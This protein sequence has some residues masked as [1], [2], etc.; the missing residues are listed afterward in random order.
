MKFVENAAGRKVPVEIN[1][2]KAT[3]FMGVNVPKDVSRKAAPPVRQKMNYGIPGEKVFNNLKDALEFC[4]IDNGQTVSTHHHLRNGDKVGGLLFD[5]IH[6]IGV[7]DVVWFP[8]ATFPCHDELLKYFEDGTIHHLEA[9][10]KGE[11]GKWVTGGHMTERGLLVVRSHGGRYLAIQNGDMKVDIAVVA[12]STADGFGNANGLYGPA[13][14]GHMG[15]AKADVE[16][17]EHVIVVTDNLVDFPMEGPWQIEGWQVDAVVKVDSIGDPEK[18]VSGT[19]RLPEEEQ[20]LYIA[21]LAAKFCDEAG[22]IKQGFS[23]QGGASGMVLAAAHYISEIMDKKGVKGSFARGGSTKYLV[24]M[25]EKGQ[26]GR[27]LDGQL[28][29]AAAVESMRKNHRT[30][31]CTNPAVSYSPHGKGRLAEGVDIA[32]LGAMEIDLEY[33]VN[34][35]TFSNGRIA[36][37]I[38]GFQNCLGG[39]CVMILAPAR[40]KENIIVR[41][42]VTT[43]VAPGETV[44]VWVSDR[45]IAIN[46]KRQDLLETIKGS[47]LP[48]RK[49]EEIQAEIKKE[50]PNSPTDIP[51][52]GDKAVGV[53]MWEDETVIDTLWEVPAFE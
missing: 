53:V 9:S 23:F 4:N 17:A 28:F 51:K 21:D 18:I 42:R 49:I 24:D 15:F 6:E 12:A 25:L 41:D 19:T 7:K 13:A 31:I 35:L 39:K 36:G 22:L 44:D 32:L 40:R 1:G 46:P 45:G 2:R 16:F 34:P 50:L 10:A 33:N 48:I 37:A 47:S 29:D 8:S 27:I 26:I 30:H 20:P 14:F 11:L 43:L 38:G 52:L 3:P 5:T